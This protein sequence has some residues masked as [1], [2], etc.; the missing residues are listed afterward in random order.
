MQKTN[1]L[2]SDLEFVVHAFK[3]DARRMEVLVGVPWQADVNET[4]DQLLL[5]DRE[6][7]RQEFDVL[8]LQ[9]KLPVQ[10]QLAQLLNL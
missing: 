3:D 8:K 6:K 2:T 5:V 7:L 4:I 10:E 1:Q 9:L